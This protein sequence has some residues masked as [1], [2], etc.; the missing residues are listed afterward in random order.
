MKKALM[1]VALVASLAL[2]SGFTTRPAESA[3]I[4][5]VSGTVTAIDSEYVHIET[6]DGNGY[7]L[8]YSERFLVGDS[9]RL[10]FDTKGNADLYDDELI[11]LAVLLPVE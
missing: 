10:T 3:H 9:V 5:T 8:Y 7:A 4:L 6:A 11:E 1:L 2:M